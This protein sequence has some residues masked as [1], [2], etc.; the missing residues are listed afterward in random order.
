MPKVAGSVKEL[1][2]A[3]DGIA[4]I[5][6]DRLVVIDEAGLRT[7]GIYDLAWTRHL[8]RGR[9]H[10]RG[11]S[12]DRLGSQPGRRRSL[13]EHP[14]AVQGPLARRVRGD[15]RSGHQPSRPDV[16]HGPRHPRDG[17]EERLRRRHLR[18]GTLRADV[19]LPARLRVRDERP[20]GRHRRRLEGPRLHP[21]RP[22]PVQRQEVRG[23]SREDDR[24]DPQGLPR[25]HRRRLPEHRHRQ[26]H[27]GGPLLRDARRAAAPELHARGRADRPHP[28]PRDRRRDRQ[29]RRRD[30][31]GRQEELHSGRAQGLPR[32]LPPRA[33]RPRQRRDR[34]LEGLRPD[35]HQPRRHAAGRTAASPRSPSTSTS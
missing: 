5:E 32:R 23:R 19:H 27:A 10:R 25:R 16:R 26:L 4:R 18:A 3:L 17:Q 7:R 35:R 12:L 21:G 28:L 31:R 6:G 2:A 20:G 30:R 14:G 8:Q 22:L 1:L 34:P 9:G 15:D 29:R 24:G 11:R 13:G 33:R